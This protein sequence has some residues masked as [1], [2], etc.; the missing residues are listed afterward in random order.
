LRLFEI[1]QREI[2]KKI[3]FNDYGWR[4]KMARCF[5]HCRRVNN[6]VTQDNKQQEI[7]VLS[8]KFL[9]VHTLFIG[10]YVTNLFNNLILCSCPFL[11]IWLIQGCNMSIFSVYKLSYVHWHFDYYNYSTH[12]HFIKVICLFLNAYTKKKK[13][14]V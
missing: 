3:I 10:S 1:K 11:F 4:D 7:Q 6:P 9:Y 2:E 12:S 14:H 13:N 8:D 5:H